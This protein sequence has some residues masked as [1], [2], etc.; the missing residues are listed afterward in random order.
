MNEDYCGAGIHV[1]DPET[2]VC[3]YCGDDLSFAEAHAQLVAHEPPRGSVVMTEGATGT[4]WQ[5]HNGDGRWH[6]TTGKA[7]S[8]ARLTLSDRPGD[9]RLFVVYLPPKVRP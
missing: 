8:W 7:T 6:S 3:E 9:G 1:R 5:R 2:G 4:A